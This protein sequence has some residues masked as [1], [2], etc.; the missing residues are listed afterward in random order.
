MALD[1]QAAAIV[2]IYAIISQIAE[3]T[4]SFYATEYI[5]TFH[6]LR[7]MSF[8]YLPLHVGIPSVAKS[9]QESLNS[10]AG[11]QI[12]LLTIRP[13]IDGDTKLRCSI[14]HFPLGM[15]PEYSAI[16]YTW[17]PLL[18][19]QS[20]E[21]NGGHLSIGY[22][23]WL[24]LMKLSTGCLP[25][26]VWIDSIC[27]NQADIEEKNSQVSFMGDIYRRA[28]K[29]LIWLGP[30]SYRKDALDDFYLRTRDLWSEHSR[31]A[32]FWPKEVD[33]VAADIEFWRQLTA[34]CR[35]PYW[36]RVWVLQEILLATC[37]PVVHYGSSS[38]DLWELKAILQAFSFKGR[39]CLRDATARQY[40]LQLDNCPLLQMTENTD[41]RES[42]L[43]RYLGDGWF[44][45]YMS[46]HYGALCSD[47]RD[48]IYALLSMA[49]P[50][51]RQR[52]GH[53]LKPDYAQSVEELFWDTLA[54]SRTHGALNIEQIWE[55]LEMSMQDMTS[56]FRHVST[57][58]HRLDR[59]F[60]S[61]GDS[62]INPAQDSDRPYY[63]PAI[64]EKRSKVLTAHQ[65]THRWFDWT[66][67]YETGSP[68]TY[69]KMH[70]DGVLGSAEPL[71]GDLIYTCDILPICGIIVRSDPE[72]LKLV[73]I[74]SGIE[75]AERIGWQ[76]LK[77][78]AACLDQVLSLGLL[79]GPSHDNT[80]HLDS[81]TSESIISDREILIVN[82]DRH[83]LLRLLQLRWRYDYKDDVDVGKLLANIPDY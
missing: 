2:Y 3:M 29:V 51:E 21:T 17:Q 47:P 71:S 9:Q 50:E 74:V 55:A 25:G 35:R 56:A 64:L 8:Q 30:E 13:R 7:D 23:I 59:P 16:S 61:E 58:Q 60:N 11:N 83:G 78:I 26:Y 76:S 43:Y 65:S 12:R 42:R 54:F 73:G 44:Q 72:Q 79:E 45:F 6:S 67:S 77:E 48:R 4:L 34:L 69:Y 1:T 19:L 52:A 62:R 80:H 14:K 24:F 53:Q 66:I 38:I 82:I 46:K 28:S 63:I 10:P 40:L 18:P 5:T 39:M 75:T 37:R 36:F 81:A 22:N 57:T 27:I 70:T 49:S 15:A 41:T 68:D 32:G 31:C 20:I 33:I